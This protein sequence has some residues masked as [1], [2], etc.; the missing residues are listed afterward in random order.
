MVGTELSILFSL[1]GYL[2]RELER[3]REYLVYKGLNMQNKIT[4]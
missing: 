1:S 3:Q 4:R 2:V